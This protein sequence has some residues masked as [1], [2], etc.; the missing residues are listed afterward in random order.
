[1]TSSENYQEFEEIP[2]TKKH[3]ICDS[4]LKL[5]SKEVVD[6]RA[7]LNQQQKLVN[8]ITRHNCKHTDDKDS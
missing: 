5:F 4:S 8:C 6:K 2:R 7:Q 3:D 1:M